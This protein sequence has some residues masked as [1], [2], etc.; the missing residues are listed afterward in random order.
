MGSRRRR[1]ASLAFAICLASCTVGSPPGFSGGESWTLPLIG[2]LEDGLLLVPAYVNNGGPYVFLIDPDAHVS[3]VDDDVVKQT[4]AHTGEG[5]H[6]LDE[7]DTQQARFF[8]E[9]LEWDFRTLKVK[10]P[11]PAQLVPAHTFDADGRRIHGVIGRDIIADSLVFSFNRDQGVVT[12]STLKQF[13]PA[14]DAIAIP[15]SLLTSRIQNA[16]VLPVSRRLVK[17]SI[18]GEQFAMHVDLGAT[19]SQLRARSWDKAKLHAS[20]LSL[21]LVDEVGIARE[22]KQ[23]AAADEVTV[24]KA[25]AKG[26]NFVPYADKRWP[27]EDLEG[28]LGLSF[29]KPYNVTVNWDKQAL[30]LYPRKDAASTIQARIARWQVKSLT[31]CPHVGCVA[32]RLIDPLAGKPADQI[33]PKGTGSPDGSLA[34]AQHPGLIASFVRDPQVQDREYEALF[35][36]TPAPGKPPLKWF[37]V[38]FPPGADRAMTHVSADYAGATLSLIDVGLF[39]RACPTENACVDLLVA[40]QRIDSNSAEL[41]PSGLLH[42]RTGDFPGQYSI[43]ADETQKILDISAKTEVSSVLQICID[44]TGSIKT[45]AITK[46]SG[47]PQYDLHILRH[48]KDT[49][50]YEPFTVAGKAKPICTRETFTLHS[51]PPFQMES[52]PANQPLDGSR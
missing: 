37:V 29:F 11:K 36:V 12:L 3:I 14:T 32:A 41:V 17:A 50:S 51:L 47:L 35:A 13:K 20:E 44:E 21:A 24:G 40:P 23:Q 16:Q 34:P 46:P 6:L 5:P 8:A 28:T 30:Y 52:R 45:L 15:Y 18:G 1:Y 48:V 33:H 2:P 7:N 22:V 10:G 39:P 42:R 43:T 26:V 38:N 31:T 4:N 25:V 9:I 19:P 27:D 49:W